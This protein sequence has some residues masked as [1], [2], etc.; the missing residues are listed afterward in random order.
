V[1]VE[2]EIITELK[3]HDW[4]DWAWLSMIDGIRVS[5]PGVQYFE[6]SIEYD[7]KTANDPADFDG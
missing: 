5:E 7:R 6:L 4:A 3:E 2:S 1:C